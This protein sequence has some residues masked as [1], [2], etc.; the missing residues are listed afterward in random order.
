[1]LDSPAEKIIIGG[2]LTLVGLAIILFH[3]SIKERYDWW[4]SRDW[5]AGL[6]SAWTGKYTR[7]GLI[8]IYAVII[9]IGVVFL[10]I[11]ISQI[12]SALNA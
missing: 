1:M 12:A 4:Q 2:L 10:A 9:L 6:G 3:R 8:F 7:G 11:G 5:P